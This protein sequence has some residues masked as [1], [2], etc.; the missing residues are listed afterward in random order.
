MKKLILLTVIG[1]FAMQAHGQESRYDST[2][3]AELGADEY[4]MKTYVMALLK[5]GPAKLEDAEHRRQVQVGHMKNISRLAEEGKL[6][7]AGPFSGDGELRGIYIF[8]VQTLEEAEALTR[9]DPAIQAG[10]LVMELHMWYG[11]A[12]LLKLPEIYPLIQKKSF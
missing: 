8:D 9:T 12:A 4:G 6:I 10:T 7:V 2:L 3:A 11:S 1:L 5:R